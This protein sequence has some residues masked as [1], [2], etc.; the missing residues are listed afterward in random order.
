MADYVRFTE[1]MI[2]THTILVPNMLPVHFRLLMAIFEHKGYKVELL[3]NDSRAVVDEGLKNVHNDACYPALLVIG[4]FMDALNSGKYDPNTTA[5]MITQTGGGCRASNYIHL[6]RKAVAKNYPQVP[7]VSLNFS[8][9]EKDS[10][11]RI[12]APMFLRLLYAV[13]Y[14]DLLMTC[15]NKCR[16]YEINKGEAKAMLD[17][18]QARLGDIFRKGSREYL[19]TKKLY[20]QILG[21]FGSIKLSDEKKIRVGIV[22]EIYVKYSPLANNHLEDFL[23][24]EGCEPVV[25][26]LLEFVMYCASGTFTDAEFYDNKSTQSRI[27]KLGYKL[28]YSKQ[29]EL[30]K[31]MKEQGSFEPLH[32]FEHLRHLA[33]K[34]ISQGVVMGEGWLIPAEMAALAQSGVDNIICTQPFGCLPNHIVAKGMSRA[35]KQDNPNANIVAIDYDPGATRVNQ[36]NRIKLMLANAKRD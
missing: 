7:V 12:T 24:S 28:I 18:W 32:D 17:K 23:L 3:E 10:A 2:K 29:K 34:Y 25:P 13:L 21:D 4:Q 30:I 36:E 11:F 26:S 22:G 20:P 16:T 8:G 35:I 1:D 33:D 9:L 15:Y 31:M 19:K 5:L 6:L 27:Y 14:G